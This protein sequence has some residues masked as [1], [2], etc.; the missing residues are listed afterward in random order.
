MPGPRQPT[1]Q[2]QWVLLSASADHPALP[3]PPALDDPALIRARQRNTNAPASLQQ[4]LPRALSRPRLARPALLLTGELRCLSRSEALIKRLSRRAALFI[5][6]T[7]PFAAA[8]RR[9]TSP[10]RL[11]ILEEH[12]DQVRID[13]DLPVPSMKQW[14]KLALALS[15]VRQVE[16]RRGH[17]FSHLIKLRSDYFYVHPHRLLQNVIRACESSNAGLVG[18]S[19]KVF[20]G[21]RDAVM[22]L[23]G[24]FAALPGWFDQ[25]EERYWPI[26]LQQVL[27]SDE[28][29]K[30]YGMNWPVELIGRPAS[31][32]AWRQQ[33][34]DGGPDLAAALARFQPG[35]DTSYH[36]LFRGHPRF[37]SEVCFARY[38]NFL[39]IPFRDCHGL[40]GFLYSDRSSCP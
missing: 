7:A 25:Q 17:R 34:I 4:R 39:G 26:N 20:A 31:T 12:P 15:L 18:A 5:V 19:D 6:T 9:L 38:L 32:E 28:A 2:P 33:L 14:H 37:A 24:F 11:L 27:A 36:R 21:R 3:T 8:A 29:L 22:L 23:E 40:R 13:H 1:H 16:Q 35:A 10:D 30:W